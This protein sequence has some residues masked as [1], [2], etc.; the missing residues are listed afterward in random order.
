[1]PY[2]EEDLLSIYGHQ[3]PVSFS[4]VEPESQIEEDPEISGRRF[5]QFGNIL[6]KM[7]NT[8]A[9]GLV[10][11]GN[12]IQGEK[13]EDYLKDADSLLP[14]FNTGPSKSWVD[15]GL[16]TVAPEIAAWMIPYLGASKVGTA[17]GTAGKLTRGAAILNEGLATG[18]ANLTT[19]SAHGISEDNNPLESGAL[20]G[21]TGALQAALPRGPRAL[22]LGA[23]SGAYGAA[24][25]KWG[26][27]G[28][29]FVGGLLP[30]A[31]GH[32]AKSIT[33][34]HLNPDIHAPLNEYVPQTGNQFSFM[35]DV[36]QGA[37]PGVREGG[38]ITP[39]YQE[40][41]LDDLLGY[42]LDRSPRQREFGFEPDAG[43][44]DMEIHENWVN[45]PNEPEMFHEP[46]GLE[47]HDPNRLPEPT[48]QQEFPLIKL[49]SENSLDFNALDREAENRLLGL[50]QPPKEVLPNRQFHLPLEHDPIRANERLL[51]EDTKPPANLDLAPAKPDPIVP[52]PKPETPVVSE[53]NWKLKDPSVKLTKSE[54]EWFD[55]AHSGAK[56]IIDEPSWRQDNPDWD[57]HTGQL[58][59]IKYRLQEQAYAVAETDATHGQLKGRTRVLDSLNNKLEKSGFFKPET[60]VPYSSVVTPPVVKPK[61]LNAVG[62]P[63]QHPLRQEGSHI[64]STA[65]R[66]NDTGE[67]IVGSGWNDKHKVIKA[68]QA[69]FHSNP[70]TL[71]FTA[72]F[73]EPGVAGSVEHGFVDDAGNF[74][75]RKD[76]LEIAKRSGQTTKESGDLHS[77]DLLEATGVKPAKTVDQHISDEHLEDAKI[78]QE[79]RKMEEKISQLQEDAKFALESGDTDTAASLGRVIKGMRQK[80]GRETA[81]AINPALQAVIAGGIGGLITYQKTKGDV[82]QSVAV[83][84]AVM[85]LGTIGIKAFEHLRATKGPEVKL[86]GVKIPD[87]NLGSKLKQFAYETK[88]TKAGLAV[89]GRGGITSNALLAGDSFFGLNKLEAFKDANVKSDGFIADILNQQVNSLREVA[90][91]K[92]SAGFAEASGKYLRGQLSNPAEVQNLL[93]SG[94]VI[95][96]EG[97][98]WSKLSNTEKGK[99]PERWLQLDDATN[100]N[101]KGDGVTVWHVTNKVKTQLLKNEHD[102]LMRMASTPEDQAFAKYAVESRNNFDTL[103][104]VVHEASGPKE[105]A[106]I[107]GTMGQYVTRSHALLSDPKYYPEEKIIQMAMAKLGLNKSANFILNN[108]ADVATP[109]VIKRTWGGSDFYVTPDKAEMFDNLYTPESLRSVVTQRIKDIKEIGAQAKAGLFKHDE[110][111]F[112]NSLFSGRKKL[113]EMTRVLLGEHTAPHEMIRDTMN[114]LIPAA[115]SAHIMLDLTKAADPVTGLPGRFTSEIEYNK[116]INRAKDLLKRTTDP[117]TQRVIQNQL[118]ELTSY[119]PVGDSTPRMGLFQG[120]YVSRGVH[121]QLDEMMNPLG[122]FE[123]VLGTGLRTFNNIFKETHLVANPVTQI[124]N[125]VQVPM[126]LVMGRAAHD[127]N[128]MKTA[129][130]IIFGGD[131]TSEV[132]RW[133]I[134]NGV[135]A[136]NAVQGELN[137]GLKELLDGTAD[138]TLGRLLAR[139]TTE[140]S[141]FK[142]I[143]GGEIRAGLHLL[144]AKPD[145]FVRTA[146]FIAAARRQAKKLGIPEDV[147][148]LDKGVTDYARLFMQRRAMDYANVPQWVKAGRQIPLLSPFLTYSHEIVRITKNMAIDAAKGDLVSGA[149]LAALTAFPFLAQQMAE[150]SLSPE[151]RKA[152]DRGQAA[153]QDYSRPRFKLPGSRNSDGSMNYY[154]ITQ[155][156]PFGDYLMMGRAAAKGDLS[157]VVAANPLAGL[158]KS[159]LLNIIASQVT[160]EDQRTH[161]DFKDGWDR[162]KNILAEITP[163]LTPGVGY[164]YEKTFP[165]SMG[166]RLGVT[167]L[168]NGRTA[169]IKGALL[170]NILGV[171]ESQV[172]PDIAVSNMVKSAQHDIANERQ[173]LRDVMMSK[174]L[175]EDAR[176]RAVRR[177]EESV[178]HIT[179][180]LQA[181]LK[182]E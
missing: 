3:S 175:S 55:W 24:T 121:G 5:K 103:M 181:R 169:T 78:L 139:H 28:A 98:A 172:N 71:P 38:T 46:T 64:T 110:A 1:M 52:T 56:D 173:Y 4:S 89:G 83:A 87:E 58:E 136:G 119:I 57:T 145:D 101:T 150:D 128:A 160:G 107:A 118:N 2:S 26:E 174:G 13:S 122:A 123:D 134:Q 170:R 104:S 146:T 171:D 36:A 43:R 157:S 144:Y 22:A 133:A 137:F 77:Q 162:T 92:P 90:K 49:Q 132:A 167:N 102:A 74:K 127:F 80:Y 61:I 109:G 11:L 126:M 39:Q 23:V 88:R 19:G 20:G 17:L 179:N 12:L 131:N 60:H 25:G 151:D 63:F 156:M 33:A 84:I 45:E 143:L 130:N 91:V 75:N 85:G 182:N 65:V 62:E 73:D 168:K 177:Y 112:T 72:R 154:D 82:G 158:D 54:Q 140:K 178:Y 96:G 40:G 21:V 81:L 125:A 53:N 34:P 68:E 79:S 42:K 117:Q 7:V 70:D 106:R 111:Q 69:D 35:D 8:T 95:A 149:G 29:N 41:P 44:S 14:T 108:Q 48:G 124:R 180:Q 165:E 66:D 129:H 67:V 16:D 32:E 152:W 115:R 163:P 51:L 138:K 135:T 100:T 37:H 86:P 164:E 94:G 176:Q 120:S 113:D 142:A 76:A 30:G 27:A 9:A 155:L 114:K 159:P 97:G 93:N 105:F 161:R 31:L 6:P 153:A 47:L 15:V 50:T 141:G 148:H 99:Y 147:M 116:A 59:D 18:F 10:G 166:G